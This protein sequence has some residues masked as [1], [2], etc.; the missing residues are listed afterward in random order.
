MEELV[1][2]EGGEESLKEGRVERLKRR[3]GEGVRRVYM[4][5]FLVLLEPN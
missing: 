3:R 5:N 2:S 1:G 4:S